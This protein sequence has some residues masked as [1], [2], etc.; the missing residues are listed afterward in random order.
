[1]IYLI[2]DTETTGKFFN[3]KSYNDPS[4]PHL[5]E[6][7]FELYNN[8]DRKVLATFSSVVCPEI[9]IPPDATRV[10]GIS[11]EMATRYGIKP[12]VASAIFSNFIKICDIVV[13]HNAD[14]DMGVMLC[15]FTRLSKATNDLLVKPVICTMRKTTPICKLPKKYPKPDDPYKWPTLDEAYRHLIN[16]EGFQGA[17][18]AI[19]DVIACREV[20]LAI[21]PNP[22]EREKGG[23]E[24]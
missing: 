6:L 7:A 8:L 15:E 23:K 10:H 21:E 18:R 12:I 22:P 4:Q 2:F 17:H 14:F 19:N 11:Q 9:P 3:N 20:L 24:K 13:A 5:V 1:M 16:K